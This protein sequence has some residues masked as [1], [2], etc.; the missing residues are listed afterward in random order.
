VSDTLSP[1][2]LAALRYAELGYRVFPC[3][4]GGKAPACARGCLEAT[5]DAE[6]IREWWQRQP[7]ANIG[8]A[9]DGLAVIDVDDA[10]WSAGEAMD[11][12]LTRGAVSATP[13]GGRHH[14][15]RQQAG[16]PV[17]NSASKLARGVDVRGDGGYIVVSPSTVDGKA[18]RWII[19]LPARNELA[20]VPDSLQA[21]LDAAAAPKAPDIQPGIGPGDKIREGFRDNACVSFLGGLRRAGASEAEMLAAARQWSGDR[22]DPPMD[23]G[24]LVVKARSV[25]RYPAGSVVPLEAV[26]NGKPVEFQ[27]LTAAELDAGSYDLEYHIEGCM[28]VGQPLILAGPKKALKTSIMLDAFI[29]IASGKP[30]LGQIAVTKPGRVAVM[31]GESGLATL[32]ESCRRIARA[33]GIRFADVSGF[34]ISPDLPQIAR[35]DHLD[36]LRKF[37][38]ADEITALGID[39]AYLCVPGDDPGNMFTMGQYLRGVSQVCTECG[40][41][42]ALAHH[43][44]KN[45]A[46]PY[47]PLELDSI[48]WSGFGEFARQWQLVN[49]REP[50]VPG[51]GEHRLWFSVGGSAGHSAL[52]ALDVSEGE[53]DG[54]TPRKWEV[55]LTTAGEAREN[56]QQLKA[57]RRE[58]NKRAKWKATVEEC[59]TA[60]EKALMLVPDHAESKRLIEDR[61]GKSGRAFDEAIGVLLRSG[62]LRETTI[63]RGNG[64]EYAGYQFRFESAV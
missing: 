9:T 56:A 4:P 22:C 29:S 43:T 62:K 24:D 21:M 10:S 39:P 49:R 59:Q 31:S 14:V 18:Y 5:G 47:Q 58:S 1:P 55:S 7:T 46:E 54:V 37:L 16:K 15:L 30:F 28:S 57:E 13:R 40:V 27:R 32:Q 26:G 3:Q 51:S 17:R 42:L 50:Y 6:Q 41:T 53:Y 12:E 61:S 34:V 52:W 64:R 63:K 60:I 38:L 25:A 23:D 2:G 45:L 35:L 11:R 20:I 36:A 19:E 48:A 33:K 8:L 44:K